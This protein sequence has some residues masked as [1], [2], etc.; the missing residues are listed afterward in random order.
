[1]LA[2]VIDVAQ[3]ERLKGKVMIGGGLNSEESEQKV[4][5]LC[6]CLINN[7]IFQFCTMEERSIP[8]VSLRVRGKVLRAFLKRSL[9]CLG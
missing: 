2:N 9:C 8:C 6:V 3:V 7:I 1:M 4:T 5:R